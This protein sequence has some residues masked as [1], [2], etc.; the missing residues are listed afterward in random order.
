M[1][2]KHAIRNGKGCPLLA[3]AVKVHGEDKF[4]IE[5]VVECA[6]DQLNQKEK[7]Y[8]EQFNCLA[9]HGYNADAGGKPGGTFK[10]HK[11]TPET[12]AKW[13]ETMKDRLESKEYRQNI[14][15]GL[16]EYYANPENRAK[17][18]ARMK[19]VAKVGYVHKCGYKRTPKIM[20]EETKQKIRDSVNK[21]Y[22]SKSENPDYMWSENNKQK[23][24]EIMTKVNGRKVGK[25][26]DQGTLIESYTS[27]KEAAEK[28][29]IAQATLWRYLKVNTKGNS[30]FWWKYIDEGE[31]SQKRV[32]NR[33]T[34]N[35]KHKEI[36]TKLINIQKKVYL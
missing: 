4:S 8:I 19:E 30:G 17:H 23:H 11:H 24:S 6:D 25:Y 32:E 18:S 36:M 12:I 1:A 31:S 35:K 9:P 14:S 34:D 20:T 7:E 5:L 3:R 29:N 2:H 33:N 27:V 22:E 28:N 10:G 13:K 21:Y 15:K 26:D 16:K